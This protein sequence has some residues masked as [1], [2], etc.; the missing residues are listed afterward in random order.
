MRELKIT[1][2]E[3]NQR[4]DK[5]L[6]R[7]LKTAGTGFLYKMMRKKN[8]LLNGKKPKGGELLKEGDEIRLYLAEETIRNFQGG[9]ER[10]GDFPVSKKLKILYEDSQI[11][12]LDK[13]AGMLSQKAEPG[14]ISANEYFLGH[15]LTEGGFAPE[16]FLKYR[17]GVCN[18]LDRNTSG[19][20]LAA[21]TLP[22]AQQA[23][24]L[25][26]SGELEKYYWT[27][28]CGSVRARA[29]VRAYLKKDERTN[30][31]RVE[32][33]PFEGGG[34]IE[35]AYEPLAGNGRATLLRVHLITGKTHQIRSHLAWLGHPVIGDAKYGRPEENRRY[36]EA[37]GLRHQLLHAEELR[38]PRLGGALAQ[39]SEKS[40]EAPLPPVFEKIAGGEGLLLGERGKS[41]EAPRQAAGRPSRTL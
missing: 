35:T 36:R 12:V 40:F 20:L 32:Q 39:L 16:D 18:R 17:P 29:H 19:L 26:R 10:P 28:V 34:L 24:G 11:A 3:E 8:I 6:N 38:F 22:A 25:L 21:K 27:I 2:N 30:R 41:A 23:A 1:K 33:A 7:Y 31:V 15:L 4:L 9:G 5:Y 14:D 13:P 37:Y